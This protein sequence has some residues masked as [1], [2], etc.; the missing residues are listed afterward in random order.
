MQQY[1]ITNGAGVVLFSCTATSFKAAVE[2][3]VQLKIPLTGA[4]LRG[5]NLGEDYSKTGDYFSA[6]YLAGANV[7][8]AE[9]EGADL[10]GAQAKGVNFDNA[11]LAGADFTGANVAN[12]TFVGADTSRIANTRAYGI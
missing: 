11:I 8:G 12:A 4:D 6:S 7:A 3:A 1:N 10:T 9:L 5:V 2:L